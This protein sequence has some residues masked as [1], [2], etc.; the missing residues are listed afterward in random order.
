MNPQKNLDRVAVY[1]NK[2][3]INTKKDKNNLT[4][5]DT[6]KVSFFGVYQGYNNANCA[7]FMKENLHNI[8]FENRYL[9]KNFQFAFKASLHE[10][11]L[12]YFKKYC[13][14]DLKPQCSQS[15]QSSQCSATIFVSIGKINF[16]SLR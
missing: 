16:L 9:L 11:Q 14:Q 1:F 8:L 12:R 10:C 15:Y 13:K 7:N 3:Q 4:I 6:I 5:K 2:I